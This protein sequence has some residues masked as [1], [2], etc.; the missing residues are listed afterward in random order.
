MLWATYAVVTVDSIKVV[1]LV[2]VTVEVVVV[3][4][5]AVTVVKAWTGISVK[6]VVTV[7]LEVYWRMRVL[8][9]PRKSF[10]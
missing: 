4:S 5:D 3:E 9:S 6:E 1:G 7:V 8:V 10:S 2:T